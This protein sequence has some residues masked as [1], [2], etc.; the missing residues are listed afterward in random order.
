MPISLIDVHQKKKKIEKEDCLIYGLFPRTN[1]T[2][3]RNTFD[4]YLSDPHSVFLNSQS[5]TNKGKKR[6][7]ITA[8][9]LTTSHI[10]PIPEIGMNIISSTCFN[11]CTVWLEITCMNEIIKALPIPQH[12]YGKT[13]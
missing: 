10:T 4:K 3:L 13:G 8:H 7:K 6:E 1:R 2:F 9:L 11:R 5:P 12:L